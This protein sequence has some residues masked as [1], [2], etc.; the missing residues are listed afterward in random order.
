RKADYEK[1]DQMVAYARSKSCRQKTIL[2]Y[3]GDTAASDCKIC[4][5]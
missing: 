4:D 3:L 5:R 2:H 1:L